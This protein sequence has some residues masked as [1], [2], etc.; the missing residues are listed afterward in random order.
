MTNNHLDQSTGKRLINSLKKGT[1][2]LDLAVYLNVGNERWYSAAD[3]FCADVEADGDSIVRFINGYY[4][5]GK[6]HFLGMLR[7]F[8]IQRR[9]MVS[10]VTL[11]NTPIHKFDVLYAEAVKNFQLPESIPMVPWLPAHDRRGVGALFAAFFT[12]WYVELHGSLTKDGLNSMAVIQ[13]V[14]ERTDRILAR[15][16]LHDLMVKA[17]QGFVASALSQ[18]LDQLQTIRSWA[19]GQ[20]GTCRELGLTRRIDANLARDFLRALALLAKNSGIKGSLLLVDEAE[21]VMD[22]SRSV[23]KKSYG[24]IRDLLDNADNQGGM[25]ASMIYIAATPEMFSS[26]N[27]FAEYEAL[28]SRLANARRF[29]IANH[30]D[31]RAV[32][33]DLVKTPLPHDHLV[34][35]A[36]K[37]RDVHAIARQWDPRPHVTDEMIQSLIVKIESGASSQVSRPRMLSSLIATLLEIAEQNPGEPLENVIDTTFDQVLQ[38]LATREVAG[39]WE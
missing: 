16:G 31:W 3:E 2:P 29:T 7:A 11:E 35:L 38:V 26:E 19:E 36:H 39:R 13:G 23:R 6:T 9:W 34:Q 20:P 15:S 24:V 27:G 28:R 12:K 37:V 8:A 21:R 18:K 30:M 22:Q 4:G 1:T 10:Y 5:D 25:P 17:I 14:K 32:I 33:I